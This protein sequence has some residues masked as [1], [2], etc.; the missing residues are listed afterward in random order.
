MD[1]PALAGGSQ[2]EPFHHH[3][4]KLAPPL[5]NNKHSF[6]VLIRVNVVSERLLDQLLA[7]VHTF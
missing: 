4:E 6:E 3:S 2:K 7:V 1:P 5:H